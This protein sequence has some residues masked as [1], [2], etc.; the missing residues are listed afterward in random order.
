MESDAVNVWLRFRL[1][2]PSLS[3]EKL[4]N[5]KLGGP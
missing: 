1:G 3:P 5:D 4:V 2:A